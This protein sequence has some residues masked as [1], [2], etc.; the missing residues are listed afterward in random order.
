M[1]K[2]AAVRIKK[3]GSS[4]R[5]DMVSPRKKMVSAELPAEDYHW[6]G[7]PSTSAF[8]DY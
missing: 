1:G 7:E 3:Q 6:Q 2:S 4:L 5:N 8:V